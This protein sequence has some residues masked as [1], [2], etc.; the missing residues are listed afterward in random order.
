MRF[1][2]KHLCAVMVIL[3]FVVFFKKNQNDFG[4]KNL[5]GDDYQSKTSFHKVI[6]RDPVATIISEKPNIESSRFKHEYKSVTVKNN[7]LPKP[8]KPTIS[9]TVNLSIYQANTPPIHNTTISQ[10][11][12]NEIKEKSPKLL[13]ELANFSYLN[14]LKNEDEIFEWAAADPN[15]A[16]RM[17]LGTISVDY[18]MALFDWETTALGDY[19]HYEEALQFMKTPLFEQ[20]IYNRANY[21]Y[22]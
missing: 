14:P 18:R 8:T 21:N 13:F 2:I 12:W 9:Q 7:H 5:L 20:M 1:P 19:M 22:E 11:K 17:A 6:K 10:A 15:L 16:F 3:S 4:L